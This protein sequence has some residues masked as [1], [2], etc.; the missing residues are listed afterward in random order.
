MYTHNRVKND[1]RRGYNNINNG[2]V[3]L[4]WC[5][6]VLRFMKTMFRS[7][8]RTWHTRACVRA[9]VSL[10]IHALFVR[11]TSCARR[12]ISNDVR[13]AYSTKTEHR[14]FQAFDVQTDRGAFRPSPPDPCLREWRATARERARAKMLRFVSRP[15]ANGPVQKP[16][17]RGVRPLLADGNSPRLSNVSGFHSSPNLSHSKLN[18]LPHK[19]HRSFGAW[20]EASKTVFF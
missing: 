8:Q 1:G 15:N 16:H 10:V 20:V 14:G 6:C 7:V 3:C 19:I 4:V 13:R 18:A 17:R 5:V 12:K 11:K 9:Y 2:Y